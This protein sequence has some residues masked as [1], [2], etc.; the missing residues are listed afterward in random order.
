MRILGF[1][2]TGSCHVYVKATSK[3]RRFNNARQLEAPR[4]R[5]FTILL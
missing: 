4:Y 2:C 1:S 5:Y 3:E